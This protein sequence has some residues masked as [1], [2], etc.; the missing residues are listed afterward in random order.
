MCRRPP[1]STPFF[2]PL[3]PSRSSSQWTAY[4][5][6]SSGKKT[7]HCSPAFR[8]DY[9]TAFTQTSTAGYFGDYILKNMAAEIT[10]NKDET[11]PFPPS[12]TSE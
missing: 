9:D 3:P 12:M 8:S 10:A 4:G 2:S 6:D 11:W 7:E 5:P 1:P